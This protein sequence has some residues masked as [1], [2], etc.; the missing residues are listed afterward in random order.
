MNVFIL[1]TGRCGSTA[2]AR[3]CKHIT[4][5]TSAHE[6]RCEL[7]GEAR[8]AYSDNHIES[9]NRLAWYL[10]RLHDK[11]GDEAY[12]V[13]LSRDRQRVAESYAGRD[14]LTYGIM[15]A[16]RGIM[17]TERELNPLELAH[18]ICETVDSNIELF[19]RDKSNVMRVRIEES[20]TWFPA[21]WDWIGAEGDRASAL[22]EF[23]VRHN[24]TRDPSLSNRPPLLARIAKK[25]QRIAQKFPEFLLEA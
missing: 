12:Y 14:H 17:I 4:N 21:F 7:M 23:T 19:L 8:L 15:Q 25:G 10:G 9:D 18:D 3:A 13:H 22:R 16:F 1:S 5:Y 2:I 24:A 11:Y 20:E 6:S